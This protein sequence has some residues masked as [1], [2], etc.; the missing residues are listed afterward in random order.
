MSQ[1]L[2]A[3]G[4]G[5][6]EWN[7]L[8]IQQYN[9]LNSTCDLW[10]YTAPS[11]NEYYIFRDPN[12]WMLSHSGYYLND[13]NLKA[14]K[15]FVERSAPTGNY[16]GT[17]G[18][19][20]GV[21]RFDNGPDSIKFGLVTDLH[22][23]NMADSPPRYFRDSLQKLTDAVNV[24]N[25]S[26]LSFVVCLGDFI[27]DNVDEPTDLAALGTINTIYQNSIIPRK[28][29]FGN[30]DMVRLTKAQFEATTGMPS[31]Y[32]S[33]DITNGPHIAHFIVLDCMY[34]SDGT[35]AEAGN[36]N[37]NYPV[38]WVSDT[39]KTWLINDLNSNLN[40][41]TYIFSHYMISGTQPAPLSIQNSA[42]IMSILESFDQVQAVFNGHLHAN[43]YEYVGRIHYV[44]FDAVV[45]NPYP[46]TAYA[47]IEL[48]EDLSITI[49]GYGDQNS[50]SLNGRTIS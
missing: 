47:I 3:S 8:Y 25:V 6:G 17:D 39:E 38:V 15:A 31:N 24:F 11:G 36:F 34:N 12:N 28:Y 4:F 46:Q 10:K 19:P 27:D 26:N 5:V 37:V 21:V 32:Y 9:T 33:F 14:T 42:D 22:Y 1:N 49:N 45:E 2:I 48:N 44:T 30:R 41:P 50:Y 43:Y 40:K 16:I 18:N 35:N 29:T 23:A 13:S 7:G 20:N